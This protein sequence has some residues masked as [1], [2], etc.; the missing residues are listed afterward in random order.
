MPLFVKAIKPKRLQLS[1]MR[2]ELLRGAEEFAPGVLVDFEAT[3]DTFKDKPTFTS[4]TELLSDGIVTY[5]GLDDSESKANENYRRLDAGAV[6]HMIYARKKR[7]LRFR[8]GYVPKTVPRVL[9]SHA[10]GRT[11]PWR[12]PKAVNH[13]GFEARDFEGTIALKHNARYYRLMEKAM[14]RA[15]K[16]AY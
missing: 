16:V 6:R 10:G 12:A 14:K 11:G 5:V 4:K 9:A 1:K 3:V 7:T 13:P 15:A 8:T 2:Q